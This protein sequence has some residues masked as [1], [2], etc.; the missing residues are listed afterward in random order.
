LNDW[1]NFVNGCGSDAACVNDNRA[2]V[3]LGFMFSSEFMSHHPELSSYPYT[4]HEFNQNFVEL[5]Y[6]IFLRR[7]SDPGGKAA[8][9]NTLDSAAPNIS[10]ANYRQ[11]ISGFT[12]STEYRVRFPDVQE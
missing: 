8:W 4:S 7:G 6:V 12:N 10:N 1:T 3:A 2:Q 11:V 5:C 9:T